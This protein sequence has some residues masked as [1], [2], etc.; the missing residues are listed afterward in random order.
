MRKLHL[1]GSKPAAAVL[2]GAVLSALSPVGL[3]LQPSAL[4]AE[5]SGIRVISSDERSLVVEWTLPERALEDVPGRGATKRPTFSRAVHLAR[6]GE[7][8]LPSAVGLL[9]IPPGEIPKV[10]VSAV[11]VTRSPFPY[12]LS[13][14]MDESDDAPGSAAIRSH[15][16]AEIAGTSSVRGQ[17]V[18]RLVFHPVRHDAGS[19]ELVWAERFIVRLDFSRPE[20]SRAGI[21]RRDAADFEAA[22]DSAL[23]NARTAR[24]WRTPRRAGGVRGLGD[25]FGSAPVWLKVPIQAG[26]MYQLDY[27]TFNDVGVDPGSVDP[28][29]IRVF[30]GSGIELPEDYSV[31]RP[32]FM[33]ECALLDLGD[34]DSVFDLSDRFVFHALGPSAWGAEYSSSLARTDH[35]DNPYNRETTYWITWGGSF[36]DPPARMTTRSAAA[37]ATSYATTAPHRIHFEEDNLESFKHRDEDG[38]MWESLFGRGDNRSYSMFLD[39]ATSPEAMVR[40]R[41]YS[42]QGSLTAPQRDVELYLQGG[43]AADTVWTH[44]AY[45]ATMDLSGSVSTLQDGTNSLVINAS[46]EGATFSDHLYLAW[47]EVE[48]E[49]ALE[50]EGGHSLSWYSDPADSVSD[51]LLSGFDAAP[52]DILLFDVTDAHETVRLTDYTVSEALS[53]HGVRMSDSPGSGVRW[54]TCVSPAGFLSLP[55]AETVEIVGLRSPARAAEYLVITHSKFREG[56]ER[57]ASLRAGFAPHPYT[58]A[59]VDI[60]SVFNEFGWG[61][62]DPSAIRDFLAYALESWSVSPLY[63]VLVGDA[64][65]DVKQNLSGSPENYILPYNNRYRQINTQYEGGDNGS[66]YATDDFFGYLETADYDSAGAQPALDVV[67]GRFPV[68]T[69]AELDV[70]LDKLESQLNY[71]TPGHWQNRVVMVADDERT[72]TD[73]ARE[74]FH[75]TQVEALANG[76]LPTA[77]ERVKIYLT[78]YPRNDFGKKPEAQ[79]AFIEEFTRGALMVTYTGHGDQNTMAHE[80][81][82]VS[83]KIPELL[84]ETRTPLFSTFSCTV[85]RFDLLGGDSMCEL[86]LFHPDGGAAVTFAS[87]G[88]VQAGTNAALNKFWLQAMFGTPYLVE[89]NSR[90]VKSVGLSAMEA[91]MMMPSSV[92]VRINNEKYVVLGD[93]AMEVRFGEYFVRFDSTTVD[94]S[95]TEGTLRVIRGRV[96]DENGQTV[97]GTHGSPAFN[98]T[99][100]VMTTETA[101]TTGYDYTDYYGVEKHIP[102]RIE[103]PT[104]FRGDTPITAGEFEV[105]FFLS[106]GVLSGNSGRVSVFALEDDL[107]RDGSGG[108]DSLVVAPT[109]S[110]EQVEDSEGPGLRISFE[111]YDS[112]VSGDYLF[113]DKPVLLV[114]LADSSGINL[115]PHPQFARLE[116]DVDDHERVDLFEDFIY[117]DGTSTTGRVRR[118]LPLGSGDHTIVVKAFDNV[119]NRTIESASFRVVLPTTDFEIDEAFTA[120]YPNPF[121]DEVA[122]VFR[123]TQAAEVTLKVFTVT[124]RKVRERGPV[125]VS[126][127]EGR[128]IWNGHDSNGTPMA[129]GT[130]I[131]LL[132]AEFDV[133]GGSR[134]TD[135]FIGRVVQMR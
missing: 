103:G 65:F 56:A 117:Q 37:S 19:R 76:Y 63:V 107:L 118:V 115:R 127:G 41:L 27:F 84:N 100:F 48:Y 88:L 116:V 11:S 85:S 3:L 60:E 34:G 120:V 72:D 114:D 51:Y 134:T 29:T 75:T 67:I 9:G 108:Y 40:A 130:Y 12:A 132:E 44:S 129:N 86:L 36:V 68:S 15:P 61:M 92:P 58:T 78:E 77:L 101:D 104:S 74:S 55:P 32:E 53:P 73:S 70:M 47:F 109:I 23:L 43:L 113:T 87:G 126:A 133:P 83:Q 52:D 79:Q 30:S 131:Y 110:P 24:R 119:G 20:T 90:A 112:F 45:L 80:E 22:F 25:S 17:R 16:W 31:A 102:Y 93:P 50:A 66:F 38:W 94:S 62:Q 39:R 121:S 14:R 98:G 125:S 42:F 7:A 28:T 49:R 97:D 135:E 8:D 124:G 122:F 123:V 21:P 35:I 13:T 71:E 105:K 6:P 26:G 69:T 57:L 89:T 111:G 2:V 4:A 46:S 96:V 59:V 82:F 81:V 33:S 54:Y 95:Y 128:I 99:A 18:A 10:T 106:Q 1:A 5:A 64:V 91:K